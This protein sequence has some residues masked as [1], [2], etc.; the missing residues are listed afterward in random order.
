MFIKKKLWLCVNIEFGIYSPMQHPWRQLPVQL[1]LQLRDLHQFPVQWRDPAPQPL[2]NAVWQFLKKLQPESDGPAIPLPGTCPKQAENRDSHTYLHTN[3]HCSIIHNR[4]KGETTQRMS[5]DRRVN[6]MW[7]AHNE[8]LL[9]H[10]VWSSDT[11][12][13][14]EEPGKH[15]GK[16][17]KSDPRGQILYDST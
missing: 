17:N 2:W 3:V 10:K 16:W 12:Y 1:H 15:N 7:D 14:L 6:K 4:Q 11:C 9:N 8:I 13:S 5:F